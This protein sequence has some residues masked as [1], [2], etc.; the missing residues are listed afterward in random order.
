MPLS[1]ASHWR[2]WPTLAAAAG[3]ALTAALGVWQYQRGA[4]KAARA[5]RIE[6]LAQEP[7]V[8]VPDRLLDPNGVELRRV[9]ASGVYEPRYAIL[10]DNR[11]W[12]GVAGYHVI[13]PLRLGNGGRYVLVNR[14]WVAAGS[15]RSRL[16]HIATPGG[17]QTVRGRAVV[18]GRH[19]LELSSQV[20]QGRVWQNLTIERY[21]DAMPIAIQP[22][23]IEQEN[24][25]A[26]DDGLTRDWP[27]PDTGVERH[28]G[29]AFQ[30]FALSVVI[31][32]FYVIAHVR[33][34]RAA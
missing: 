11:V 31:V 3:V 26:P 12:H 10:L 32:V 6:H 1:H 16:P 24:A 25:G 5:E 13:M 34:N 4:E 2:G 21:R 18:P 30:W 14:G 27:A 17:T 22:F 29:Y 19:F 20:A 23:M 9:E 8:H 15:D 28:Y 7:P 33:K